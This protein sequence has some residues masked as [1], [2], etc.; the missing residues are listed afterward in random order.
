MRR[1]NFFLIVVLLFCWSVHTYAQ[2]S[3]EVSN[4]SLTACVGDTIFLSASG[5]QSYEWSH[6]ATLSCDTC[7]DPYVILTDTSSYVVVKGKDQNFQWADNGNFSSGNTGFLSNYTYNATSIWNASTYAV[8]PNPNAVHPNFGT[9]GDHTTGTGNYMLVNGSSTGTKILWRQTVSLPPGAQVTMKWWM[10]TF[11]SPAGSLQLKLLGTN[12]GG[13]ASTPSSTGIWQ[14]TSRSFTAPASGSATINLVTLSGAGS[15]NDFGIDDISLEYQCEVFDTVWLASKSDPQILLD[16]TSIFGCDSVCFTIEN[17]LDTLGLLNYQ[18]ILTD[19]TMDSNIVFN[20][21]IRDTGDYLGYLLTSSFDGC[22]DSVALPHVRVGHTRQLDS[23]ITAS[24]NGSLWNGIWIMDP[25]ETLG[26]GAHFEASLGNN[27]MQD[28]LYIRI[29]S[30][31]FSNGNIGANQMAAGWSP[32][33]VSDEPFYACAYLFTSEGCVDSLCREVAFY[34]SISV[35]NFLT[36]NGDGINDEL[37]IE[38]SNAVILHQRIFNRWGQLIYESFDP[39]SMWKGTYEGQS[40]APGVY[41]IDVEA[42]NPYSTSP[43]THQSVIHVID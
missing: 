7:T 25:Q 1:V 10:L 33:T 36:P 32:I 28:S 9:W 11:V 6:D 27:G 34:P 31:G 16:T 4:D 3:V 2:C 14:Q 15:G 19:G 22:T 38:H 41:F 40:V 26:V 12:V 18:W 23:L 35:P 29:G 39:S 43:V 37:Y 13:T 17:Q 21:C 42:T 8:G 24:D 30:Q 20:H 5:S